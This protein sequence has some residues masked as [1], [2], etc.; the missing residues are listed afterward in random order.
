MMGGDS[1][2][3]FCNTSQPSQPSQQPSQPSSYHN[4]KFGTQKLN[5]GPSYARTAKIPRGSRV[6]QY[7]PNDD[8]Y[9]KPPFYGRA[10]Y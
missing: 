1:Y 8:S 3:D 7:V 2:G 5:L 9:A 4:D 6:L 10:C